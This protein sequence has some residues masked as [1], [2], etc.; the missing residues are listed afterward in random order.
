MSTK[1][2]HQFSN[3]ASLALAVLPL[4]IIIAAVT[5]GAVSVAGL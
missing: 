5:S 2:I 1:S 4:F 3:V